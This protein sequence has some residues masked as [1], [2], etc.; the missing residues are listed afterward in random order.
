RRD[1]AALVEPLWPRID[2]LEGD[3]KVAPS[4]RCVLY[5]NTHHPGSQAIYVQTTAGTAA[6]VADIARNVVG[7][8]EQGIPP[9]LFYDLEAT[10]RATQRIRQEAVFALPSHDYAIATHYA[11][12]LPAGR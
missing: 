9:G 12:G 4:V 7:N 6:I 2:L 3:A 5:A 8:I 10:R 11:D 1:I